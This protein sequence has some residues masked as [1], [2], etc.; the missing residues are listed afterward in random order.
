MLSDRDLTEIEYRL[1]N[2]SLEI[3]PRL[4]NVDLPALVEEVKS[5]Q[6]ILFVRTI[7]QGGVP[8]GSE[9]GITVNSDVEGDEVL[10][11]EQDVGEGGGEAAQRTE[12][13]PLQ[14]VEVREPDSPSVGLI[15]SGVERRPDGAGDSGEGG[16]D[17]GIVESA[18]AGEAV[19]RK[20][21]DRRP[22]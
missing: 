22:A 20:R 18:G 16:G 3:L 21:K 5:L 12:A 19:G 13:R 8:Y 17:Q 1:E 7:L 14:D 10:H 2:L 15:P 4:I 9:R 11:V 6:S